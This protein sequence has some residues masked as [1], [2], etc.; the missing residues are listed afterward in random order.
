M[1]PHRWVVYRD[2]GTQGWGGGAVTAWCRL[3][4][5]E[6][7]RDALGL[8]GLYPSNHATG[9]LLGGYRLFWEQGAEALDLIGGPSL[10]LLHP[11][12]DHQLM[13]T[14]TFDSAPP[15]PEDGGCW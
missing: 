10:V 5:L 11:F 9:W 6:L 12:T 1:D 8:S 2:P 3:C 14:L 15:P 4:G 7:C 13:I